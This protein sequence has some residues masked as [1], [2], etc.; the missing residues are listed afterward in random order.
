[1][2]VEWRDERAA[3]RPMPG[4]SSYETSN[5]NLTVQDSFSLAPLVL[6]SGLSSCRARLDLWAAIHRREATQLSSKTFAI[7]L[8]YS[9]SLHVTNSDEVVEKADCGWP[10]YSG[11]LARWLRRASASQIRNSA[12]GLSTVP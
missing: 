8:N 11:S 2:T 12:S 6:N 4:R 7:S 10:R 1:M 3:Y 5:C 9:R